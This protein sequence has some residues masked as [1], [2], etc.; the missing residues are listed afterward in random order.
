M[1]TIIAGGRDYILSQ[2]DYEY[3]DT[4]PITEVVCGC[5]TG[6]DTCGEEWAKRKRIPVERF[7]ADWQRYGK[8][9]GYIRN[10]KMAKYAQ[11][12][13]LFPGGKGT[14]NMEVEAKR[15]GL[16]IWKVENQLSFL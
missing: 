7:P 2:Q 15:H 9:A 4:L 3:L 12:C 10:E 5:A 16:K 13:V 6:A 14:K 1:K 11:A 8:S